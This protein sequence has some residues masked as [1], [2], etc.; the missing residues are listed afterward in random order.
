MLDPLKVLATIRRATTLVRAAKGRA[1]S[2]VTPPPETIDDALVVGDLHGH[3]E[4]FATALKQA[5]LDAHPR[6]HLIVQELAHDNRVDPDE[7]QIDHSHRLIDLACAVI[8]K[9]P[10]RVHYL[11]GNHELS[12]LTGR[13]ISKK[14]VALNS[15]FAAG[16]EADYP[17]HSGAFLHAYRDLF[18]ALPLAVR[19][20]NRVL[21]CHT[22]PDPRDLDSFDASVY[23]A[24]S[25]P[26]ELTRRG[27]PVYALTWGRDT[28]EA[29]ADRFA[30]LV[31]A[32]LFVCGHQPCDEGFRRANHRVLILDGT[33]PLPSCCLVST[34][35]PLTID[36]LVDGA[37]HI[38]PVA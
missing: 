16:V 4:V 5:A 18:A 27:G 33:D 3:V 8:G 37:R 25:W 9:Y 7:G 22:V 11:L 10:D 38:H 20:P 21:V 1:G 24:T 35:S 14:G 12:E 31:D 26:D 29:T 23:A 13:S 15:L 6:R 34:R 30:A 28:S 17:G 36:A 2:L 19:L 32:D